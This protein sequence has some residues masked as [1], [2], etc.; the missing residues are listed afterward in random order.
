MKVLSRVERRLQITAA[1]DSAHQ[2]ND[3]VELLLQD[4]HLPATVLAVSFLEGKVLYTLGVYTGHLIHDFANQ[5]GLVNSIGWDEMGNEFIRVPN[6]DSIL[7]VAPDQ[8]Q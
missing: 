6:I 5:Y 1:L 7:V 2:I 3:R 4:Y 8:V